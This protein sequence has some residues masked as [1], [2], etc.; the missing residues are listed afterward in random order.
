M[1]MHAAQAPFDPGQP[2]TM[3]ELSH[4]LG[5]LTDEGQTWLA[6]LPAQIFF[7]RQ[8]ERW[9]PV[10]HVR[11]LRKSALPVALGLRLPRLALRALFGAPRHPSR[12]FVTLRGDY[13]RKLAAGGQAGR[14]APSAEPP[15]RDA[16]HR[17]RSVLAAWRKATDSVARAVASWREDDADRS[18]LPHPLLGG[19]TVREMAAFTV[20]HTVHHLELARTRLAE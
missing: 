15:P 8:G 18:R 20:Y 6:A 3:A 2:T 16:E 9:A 10:E 14:F 17:R 12:D 11:H 19:L 13:R 4:T 1:T 7:A 5:R